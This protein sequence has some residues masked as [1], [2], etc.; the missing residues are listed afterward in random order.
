MGAWTQGEH[1]GRDN[2]RRLDHDGLRPIGAY[3]P[4]GRVKTEEIWRE[5]ALEPNRFSRINPCGLLDIG[6][7]YI[8]TYQIIAGPKRT[9]KGSAWL[10]PRRD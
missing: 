10:W 3:A 4:A 6:G 8:D 5:L 1:A 2:A 9:A 7:P